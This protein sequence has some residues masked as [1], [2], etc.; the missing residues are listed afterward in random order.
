MSQTHSQDAQVGPHVLPLHGT[1]QSVSALGA[2]VIGQGV[3]HT[4]LRNKQA[5]TVGK[6]GA[7][8]DVQCPCETKTD[9]GVHA[10]G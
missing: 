8:C 2:Q 6:L 1:S 3:R 7:V 5:Q 10:I 4:P 9:A